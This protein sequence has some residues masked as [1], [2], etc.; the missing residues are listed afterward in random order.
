MN[1]NNLIERLVKG[2]PMLAPEVVLEKNKT[3]FLEG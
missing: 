2:N 3:A 1:A